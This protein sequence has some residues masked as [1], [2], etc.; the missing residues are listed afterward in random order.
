MAKVS[1]PNTLT[2]LG[3]EIRSTL[4][5][6]FKGLIMLIALMGRNDLK[7]LKNLD[8]YEYLIRLISRIANITIKKSRMFQPSHKYAFLC[9]TKPL[10]IILRMLSKIKIPLNTYPILFRA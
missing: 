4:T 5:N 10:E 1:N 8:A 6:F 7:D 9:I 3:K 2:K